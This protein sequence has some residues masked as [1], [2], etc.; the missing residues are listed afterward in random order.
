MNTFL[1]VFALALACVYA[2]QQQP[3]PEQQAQQEL[4][5]KYRDTCIQETGVNPELIVKADNGEFTDNDEKLQCFT[6]CFYQKAGFINEKGDILLD[7]I[8]AKIPEGADKQKALAVIELCKKHVGS[9][10]CEN[11]Y[12]VH[13]CYFLETRKAAAAAGQQ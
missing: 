6:K 8:E 11:A 9:N 7:V 12:L 5:L 4:I 1:A 2:Q 10:P 3:T 13:K